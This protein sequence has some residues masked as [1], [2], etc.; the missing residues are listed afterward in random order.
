MLRQDTFKS[1]KKRKQRSKGCFP[2]AEKAFNAGWS[3]ANSYWRNSQVFWGWVNSIDLATIKPADVDNL[4]S[5]LSKRI[6]THHDNKKNPIDSFNTWWDK[7]G[8]GLTIDRRLAE[9]AYIEALITRNNGLRAFY[10][11][12]QTNDFAWWA[13]R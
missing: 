13:N 9:S 10:L 4:V 6:Q 12:Y 8:S 7:N 5:E 3:N 1:W 2:L 11:E